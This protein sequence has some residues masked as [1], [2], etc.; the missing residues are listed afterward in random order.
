MLFWGLPDQRRSDF[1]NCFGCATVV[2]SNSKVAGLFFDVVEVGGAFSQQPRPNQLFNPVAANPT[3]K[4]SNVSAYTHFA[5]AMVLPRCGLLSNEQNADNKRCAPRLAVAHPLVYVNVS[6]CKCNQ[7]AQS[8]QT[9]HVC[10]ILH[11][12]MPY[13]P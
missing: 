10:S 13:V 4:N 3:C 2:F 11:R 7:N 6:C 9:F 5:T 1:K 8:A 12:F